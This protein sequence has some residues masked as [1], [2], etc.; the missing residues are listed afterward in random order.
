VFPVYNLASPRFSVAYDLTG[1]GRFALKGSFGQYI[2]MSSS[3]NSQ[4]G[5]GANSSGVNPISTKSC[6]FNNWDGTIPYVPV[7]GAE[8]YLGSPTNVNLSGACTGGSTTA[9]HN[10]DSN[11]ETAR[12]IEYTA[13]VDIGLSRNYAVRMNMSRKFDIGGSK[14][15]N[16]LSPYAA[17]TDVR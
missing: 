16:V 3:P 6:T 7:F 9:L 8:N 13:G 12:M 11:L 15:V 5:P 2:N 17:Y 10:F 14:T 1:S 4:P